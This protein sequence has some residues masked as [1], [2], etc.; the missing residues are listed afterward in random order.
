MELP[1]PSTEAS[2]VNTPI[3]RRAD[4]SC[5]PGE[6]FEEGHMRPIRCILVAIKD[7]G[8]RSLPAVIKAAQ[9]ARACGARVELFHAMR[10]SV[11]ADTP[12]AYEEALTDLHATHRQEFAQRLGRIA[13]RLALHDIKASVAVELDYPVYDAIVRRARLIGADLIVAERHRGSRAAGLLRLTDWELLRQSPVPVLLVRRARPYHRPNILAAVDPA[14]AHSK[15]AQLDTEILSAG[16]L[17][18]ESLRGRLHAVHAHP[19]MTVNSAAHPVA[20]TVTTNLDRIASSFAR[21]RFRELLNG[22]TVPTTRRYF[23]GGSPTAAISA[24]AQKTRADIVVLGAL[25]RSG[26]KRLFIGNTAEE[27]F[28]KLTC[29]LLIVKPASFRCDVPRDCSGPRLRTRRSLSQSTW[30]AR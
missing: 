15:P 8:L 14:H 24:I 25:S 11:Y 23:L 30:E 16:Q 22:T 1:G 18:S 5:E 6:P 9:I 4:E 10:A 20:A 19:R 12:A 2:T 27:L 17:L 3:D 29:D 26:L 13:A 21:A 28:D 7:P